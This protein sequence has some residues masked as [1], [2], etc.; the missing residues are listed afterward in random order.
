MTTDSFTFLRFTVNEQEVLCTEVPCLFT[1]RSIVK[2]G[3]LVTVIVPTSVALGLPLNLWGLRRA[4]ATPLSTALDAKA[5]L[6][7]LIP[8]LQGNFFL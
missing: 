1:N 5:V 2:T 6:L 4:G 8:Q 7:I 3:G